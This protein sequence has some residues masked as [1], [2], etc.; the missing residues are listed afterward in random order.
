MDKKQSKCQAAQY[1]GSDIN[2]GDD[3]KD[4]KKLQREDIRELNNNPRNNDIDK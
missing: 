4:S 3:C 1:R 2:K